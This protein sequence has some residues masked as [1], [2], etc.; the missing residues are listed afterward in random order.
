MQSTAE[1]QLS[2]KNLMAQIQDKKAKVSFLKAEIQRLQSETDKR[3][4]FSFFLFLFIL[5]LFILFL[6]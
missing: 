1:I 6:F 2:N 3:F 5:F 4:F